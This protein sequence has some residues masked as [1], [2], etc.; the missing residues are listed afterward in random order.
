MLL[1]HFLLQMGLDFSLRNELCL[2]KLNLLIPPRPTKLNVFRWNFKQHYLPSCSTVSEA[3]LIPAKML[4][5]VICPRGKQLQKFKQL[6]FVCIITYIGEKLIALCGF[7]SILTQHSSIC[8]L[9]GKNTV[10]SSPIQV[11]TQSVSFFNMLIVKENYN[12]ILTT[13]VSIV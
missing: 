10:D 7:Y 13:T 9:L 3:A 4:K 5:G 2:K 11:D 6:G 1:L 8:Q 12:G